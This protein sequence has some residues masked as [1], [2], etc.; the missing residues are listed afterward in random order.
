MEEKVGLESSYI[1]ISNSWNYL[2][3]EYDLKEKDVIKK[4]TNE[5]ESKI[6]TIQRITEEKS[7]KVKNLQLENIYLEQGIKSCSEENFYLKEELNKLADETNNRIEE[8]NKQLELLQKEKETNTKEITDK[9]IREHKVEMENI[10][11]RYRLM[12]KERSI[13]GSNYDKND[14]L[15]KQ[16]TISQMQ[17]AFKLEKNKIIEETISSEAKKWQAIL[18]EKSAEWKNN[19]ELEKERLVDEI[20]K[21]I[22]EDKDREIDM[23]REREKN[24]NLENMKYKTTIQKLTENTISNTQ[25]ELLEKFEILEQRNCQLEAELSRERN[26]RLEEMTNKSSVV[27]YEGKKYLN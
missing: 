10:R 3:T 16:S 4:L 14:R 23:F 25:Q 12:T 15:E 11:A 24:L 13:L 7:E 2:F 18:E 9:L 17:E 19:L 8:L 27:V 20:T 22:L 5:Y 21:R 26:K 1:N 6:N